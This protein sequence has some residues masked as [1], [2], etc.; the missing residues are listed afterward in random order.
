[1]LLREYGESIGVGD[2]YTRTPVGVFLGEPGR[3]VPDPYFGGEGPDRTGCVRCG[4]CMIGC[5]Y[6]AKNTLV[7]NYLWFAE[8]LGVD[9]TAGAR[10]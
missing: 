5:R 10:S 3:T 9:R 8:K 4:G 2:T 1:M 6:G 7:K